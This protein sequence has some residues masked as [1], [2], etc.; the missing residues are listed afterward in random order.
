MPGVGGGGGKEGYYYYYYCTS[1][2][3]LLVLCYRSKL[4]S[5]LIFL[6]WVDF[7]FP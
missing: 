6:S 4:N 1:I 2:I 7:E 3:I 5:D